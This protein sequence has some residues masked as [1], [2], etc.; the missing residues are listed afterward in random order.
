VHCSGCQTN[1]AGVFWEKVAKTDALKK[2]TVT[3]DK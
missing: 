1:I 3:V 2:Q